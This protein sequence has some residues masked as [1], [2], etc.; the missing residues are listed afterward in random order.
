MKE[1]VSVVVRHDPEMKKGSQCHRDRSIKPLTVHL[2]IGD[3]GCVALE[4]AFC[5]VGIQLWSRHQGNVFWSKHFDAARHQW[6]GKEI[7][8]I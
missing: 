3:R 7:L 6:L 1:S 4:L 8:N 2:N 5:K